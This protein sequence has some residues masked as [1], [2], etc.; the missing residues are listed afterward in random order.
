MTPLPSTAVAFPRIEPS[1]AALLVV[2]VQERLVAA[3]DPQGFAACER[4]ILILVELARRLRLPIVQSEQVPSKLGPTVGTLAAALRAAEATQPLHRL[5]KQ[6]FAVTD[7]PAFPALYEGVGRAQ[8]IVVGLE[9]HICVFQSTRGLRTLGT[10]VFLPGDAT[11][12]RVPGNHRVGLE[13]AALCGAVV[14][15]T[16]TV[17]FDALGRAGTDDFR[18]ISRLVR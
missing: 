6:S 14:T 5:E 2:D 15:S 7:D 1:R 16:E 17:A 12:A 18:A 11:L 10:E 4:N 9:A 3:M 8:W 13:L